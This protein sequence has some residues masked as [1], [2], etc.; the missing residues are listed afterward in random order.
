MNSFILAFDDYSNSPN[1][2]EDY[3]LLKEYKLYPIDVL[4][5]L[6]EENIKD[7]FFT[8]LK[9]K[10]KHAVVI[11]E[12]TG[13]KEK[14]KN[15][16]KVHNSPFLSNYDLAVF[17]RVKDKS[18]SPFLIGYEVKGL[19]K[20]KDK[21]KYRWYHPR[22]HTGLGQSLIHFEQDANQSYL[23]TVRRKNHAEN[24]ALERAIKRQRYI[25]LIFADVNKKTRKIKF[26]LIVKPHE[27]IES[28]NQDR[29]KSNLVIVSVW[30]RPCCKDIQNKE[31]ARNAEF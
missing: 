10:Y 4:R 22:I 15:Q 21:G 5:K 1:I 24:K 20:K 27:Y 14:R 7:A 12:W 25:G 9:K 3:E 26:D 23:V 6:R 17:K 29:K 2:A 19:Q 30:N 31:W 11:L 18:I 13:R 28:E 16:R 8:E